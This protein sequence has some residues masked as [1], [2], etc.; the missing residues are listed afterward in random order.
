MSNAPTST[1]D[2]PANRFDESLLEI[3]RCPVTHSRLRLAD[4]WLVAETGGLAYPIRDGIP[5]MLPES[6]RLPGGVAT[7]D[8]FRS[9]FAPARDA[10]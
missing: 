10:E 5:V 1:P 6:A 3:L 7:L 4:G 2:E 8:E 9:R